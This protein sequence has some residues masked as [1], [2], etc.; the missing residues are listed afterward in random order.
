MPV[1]GRRDH[2]DQQHAGEANR[3]RERGLHRP[4]RV[5][6]IRHPAQSTRADPRGR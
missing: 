5:I 6:A 4:P 2:T 3:Q 1:P